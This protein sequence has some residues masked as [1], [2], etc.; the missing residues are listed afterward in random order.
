M[1]IFY[2]W[3]K[4][5]NPGAT[6]S[7]GCWTYVKWGSP[8][9]LT[10]SVNSLPTIYVTRKR[11]DSLPSNATDIRDLG[12]I[13]TNKVSEPEIIS[14]WTFKP[15]NGTTG[16]YFQTDSHGR[17]AMISDTS[18]NNAMTFYGNFN[19]DANNTIDGGNGGGLSCGEF[20][21]RGEASLNDGS[22]YVSNDSATCSKVF[23]CIPNFYVGEDDNEAFVVDST[24]KTAVVNGGFA[25]ETVEASSWCKAYYFNATSDKRAKEN[26]TPATYNALDVINNLQIY[27]FNYKGATEVV[28]GILAQDLLEAQPKDLDL[29]SNINATGENGDYMSIKNDKLMF[30]LMK[31]IQEQQEQI[32]TLKAEIEKLK[33]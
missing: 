14:N 3:I 13:L 11:F 8:T 19:V 17:T 7:S 2:K 24:N 6:P 21:A 25:A 30:V 29:V 28:T 20:I 15:Y 16:I 27:N 31:A 23:R 18:K 26:I 9:T 22:F 1:A 10:N 12:Y 33:A 5:C 4:G 32:E